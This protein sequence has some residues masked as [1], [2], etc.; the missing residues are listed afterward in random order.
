MAGFD[1]IKEQKN[2][3]LQSEMLGK[4]GSKR[5]SERLGLQESAPV[6]EAA[7]LFPGVL[8]LPFLLLQRCF[9]IQEHLQIVRQ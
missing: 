3:F 5:E 2:G 1:A 4:R 9:A 7:K 6:I 8:F